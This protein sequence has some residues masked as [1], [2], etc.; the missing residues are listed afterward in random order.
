MKTLFLNLNLIIISI[1]LTYNSY[2]SY[3][4]VKIVE[5]LSEKI[6]ILETKINTIQMQTAAGYDVYHI[7]PKLPKSDYNVVP[8]KK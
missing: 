4:L 3:I 7:A 8:G 6:D 2:N 5:V 1:I